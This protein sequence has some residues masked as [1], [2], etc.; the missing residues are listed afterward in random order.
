MSEA[1]AGW[2]RSGFA[3]DRGLTWV[4]L[5]WRRWAHREQGNG[6]VMLSLPAQEETKGVVGPAGPGI[7]SHPLSFCRPRTETKSLPLWPCPARQMQDETDTKGILLLLVRSKLLAFPRVWSTSKP[8]CLA[9]CR[10]AAPG[11]RDRAV[12]SLPS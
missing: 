4:G 1:G 11:T 12:P 5:A 2:E 7:F 6:W 3:G 9:S 8:L 10:P